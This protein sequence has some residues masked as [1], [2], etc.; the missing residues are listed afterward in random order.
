MA[1]ALQHWLETHPVLHRGQTVTIRTVH[2]DE[3][4]QVRD[5]WDS[6]DKGKQIKLASVM[7]LLDVKKGN[8]TN[9]QKFKKLDNYKDA[10]FHEIKSHQIRIGCVWEPG[11]NL[12]LLFGTT[13]K[14]DDWKKGD[15]EQ[16]QNIYDKYDAKKQTFLS[17]NERNST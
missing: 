14:Q 17:E 11:Y 4:S 5:Y 6:L 2:L 15:L 12:M 7:N 1:S 16:L 3:K 13:K 9:D 10:T 8:V